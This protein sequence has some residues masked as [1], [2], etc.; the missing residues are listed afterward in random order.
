MT[1]GY[2]LRHGMTLSLLGIMLVYE[3]MISFV[4]PSK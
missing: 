1:V 2:R 3:K 4:A